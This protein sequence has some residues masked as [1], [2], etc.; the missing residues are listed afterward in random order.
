MD[1]PVEALQ[2]VAEDPEI[3]PAPDVVGQD[4]GYGLPYHRSSLSACDALRPVYHLRPH[5]SGIVCPGLRR[6]TG[7]AQL[8]RP[9]GAAV[10]QRK[11]PRQGILC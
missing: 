8:A 3:A 9:Q 1:L 4:I 5:L 10:L 7:F 2:E 6:R 11:R